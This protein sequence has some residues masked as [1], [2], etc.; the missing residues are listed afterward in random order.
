MKTIS[1]FLALINSLLAGLLI[2]YS[3]SAS[4]IRHVVAWWLV[5]KILAGLAVIAAGALAWIG[6]V[7]PIRSS[8]MIL[9][10]LLLVALGA[11]TLMWS[12]H[13]GLV[14]SEIEYYMF[15]YGGS[16]IIQGTASLFGNSGTSEN[17][18]VA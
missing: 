8:V 10:S 2:I 15:L 18:T 9:S 3:L 1:I 7:K 17:M 13:L 5:I 16:L 12:L 6:S 14:T 4:E 11:A